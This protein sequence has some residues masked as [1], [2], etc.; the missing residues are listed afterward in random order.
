MGDWAVRLDGVSKRYPKGGAGYGHLGTAIAEQG[1][2]FYT[3]ARHYVAKGV[4]TVLY[5][6]GPRTP[7][8]AHVHGADERLRLTDLRHAT[9]VVACAVA[10]LL[11]V[12]S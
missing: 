9:V 3:D 10:E 1:V 12:R 11:G 5:G 4:P 7:A 2:P 8:Q 6:A